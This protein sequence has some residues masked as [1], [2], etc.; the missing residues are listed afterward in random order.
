MRSAF[1]DD[2]SGQKRENYALF[3]ARSNSA[4]DYGFWNSGNEGLDTCLTCSCV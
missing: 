1:N 3:P 4:R 2:A